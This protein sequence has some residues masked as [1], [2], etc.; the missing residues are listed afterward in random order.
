MEIKTTM[1]YHLIPA[2]KAITKKAKNTKCGQ[3][4]GEK[5]SLVHGWWKCKVAW[6]I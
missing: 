2:R 3:G 4:C 1:R 6:P 5:V